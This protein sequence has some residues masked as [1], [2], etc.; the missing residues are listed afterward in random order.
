MVF[1]GDF[2]TMKLILVYLLT[3]LY[4]LPFSNSLD[5]PILL[6]YLFNSDNRNVDENNEDNIITFA[7]SSV[8]IDPIIVYNNKYELVGVENG[9]IVM[10][11]SLDGIRVR[12]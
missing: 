8:I 4:L 1:C 2:T 6:S 9:N 11:E 7:S 5:T 12:G 10:S 3:I